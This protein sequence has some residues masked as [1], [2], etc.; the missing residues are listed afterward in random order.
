MASQTRK[1]SGQVR[2]GK[3]TNFCADAAQAIETGGGEIA[4]ESELFEKNGFDRDDFG[5]SCTGVQVAHQ[6]QETA[7]ERRIR[8]GAERTAVTAQ[9]R[10][11]PC[12]GNAA[13]Y[14]VRF[15]SFAVVQR[16]HFAG[17][18]HD[19]GEPFLRVIDDGVVPDKLLLFF[20]QG[21]A[22]ILGVSTWLAS[23]ARNV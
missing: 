23:G 14:P 16:W 12:L 21:H 19:G 1:R 4:G 18:V 22:G 17:V 20:D 2:A 13:F 7:D 6:F 15:C 5:R 9:V 10:D 11:N 3:F 8:V